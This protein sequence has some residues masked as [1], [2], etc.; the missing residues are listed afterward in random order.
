VTTKVRRSV[1]GANAV[2]SGE[3]LLVDGRHRGWH[4]R[5][6]LPLMS[7]NHQAGA[8]WG[9]RHKDRLAWDVAV[10][11]A[12]ITAANIRNYRTY[13]AICAKHPKQR[14]RLV[15]TR[16]VP[17]RRNFIKD[18]DDLK[19]STKRLLDALKG[20]QLCFDDSRK[21]LE[22]GLPTQKVS[23]DGQYWTD[24]VIVQIP[25]AVPSRPR[26]RVRSQS[27]EKPR[28]RVRSAPCLPSAGVMRSVLRDGP[29]RGGQRRLS[30][31]PSGG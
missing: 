14:V 21:W 11:N 12:L 7:G 19:W 18:D 23:A 17:S 27:S 22:Y 8:H 30:S 29:R 1:R 28:R 26:P 5:I 20:N 13:L 4:L 31:E 9:T 2:V 15:I 3:R 6:G 16:E 10:H 24:I 25:D